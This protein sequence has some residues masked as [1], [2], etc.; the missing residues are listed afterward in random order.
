L[1]AALG[2]RPEGVATLFD[3]DLLVVD[4]SP[5]P[6][7]IM[8]THSTPGRSLPRFVTKIRLR[9]CITFDLTRDMEL[10]ALRGEPHA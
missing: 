7:S 4:D 3:D 9:G 1:I 8:P 2:G 6:V 5:Q 10:T